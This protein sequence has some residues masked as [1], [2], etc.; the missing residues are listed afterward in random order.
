ETVRQQYRDMGYGDLDKDVDAMHGDKRHTAEQLMKGKA[1]NNRELLERMKEDWFYNRKSGNKDTSLTDAFGGM[2]KVVDIENDQID[3][4]LGRLDGDGT[5]TNDADAHLLDIIKRFS[6][7]CTSVEPAGTPASAA[8]T[9]P[10][11]SPPGASR[12]SVTIISLFNESLLGRR[13]VRV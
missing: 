6:R 1:K 3:G 12:R 2:G 4:L 11:T 8:L 13:R 7:S 10:T 5:P 9:C